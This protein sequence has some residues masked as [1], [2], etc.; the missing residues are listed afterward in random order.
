MDAP[1]DLGFLMNLNF[2]K[3]LSATKLN[4]ASAGLELSNVAAATLLLPCLAALSGV[5]PFLGAL[6]QNM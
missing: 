1:P 5:P 4:P 3:V 6:Y 2:F